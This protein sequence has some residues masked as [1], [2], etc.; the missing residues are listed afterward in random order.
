MSSSFTQ[1]FIG[2]SK[3]FPS[4]VLE[5]NLMGCL[6][7]ADYTDDIISGMSNLNKLINLNLAGCQMTQKSCKKLSTLI[8]KVESL[9]TLDVSHCKIN[10]QGTRYI[11]DA[12][13]RNKCINNFMFSGNDLSSQS[14][15]FSIKVASMITRHPCLMHI[16]ISNTN[17]KREEILFIGMSLSTSKTMLSCHLTSGGMTYY[18]R[19]F[20]RS[21]I[22]A[23]VSF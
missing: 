3:L 18:D 13:N 5:L 20:L 6:N 9:R 15:E 19:V 21:V 22:A 14:N 12:L 2:M 8:V 10:Y 4:K 7:S 11:I 17:L 16:D 1:T 23:R